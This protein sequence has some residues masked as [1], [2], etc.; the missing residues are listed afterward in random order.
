MCVSV[1]VWSPAVCGGRS[2]VRACRRQAQCK[3][4]AWAAW[5]ERQAEAADFLVS[6]AVWGSPGTFLTWLVVHSLTHQRGRS[7]PVREGDHRYKVGLEMLVSFRGVSYEV[8]GAALGV[9][10]PGLQTPLLMPSCVPGAH[11]GFPSLIFSFH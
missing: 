4:L 6:R 5:E 7:P 1:C 9:H 8:G 2:R 3:T 11:R 10:C